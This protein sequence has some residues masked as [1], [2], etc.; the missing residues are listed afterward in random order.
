MATHARV[1]W[2]VLNC[3][4]SLMA[5]V[6]MFICDG[7]IQ[8]YVLDVLFKNFT[9]HPALLNGF[10]EIAWVGGL[11]F[12]LCLV[13]AFMSVVYMFMVLNDRNDYFPDTGVY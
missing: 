4:I 11:V 8:T 6:V 3:A 12:P 5:C 7:F 9:I 13:Y 2:A 1:F 10:N